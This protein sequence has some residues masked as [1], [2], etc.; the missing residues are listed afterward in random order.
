MRNLYVPWWG[1]T[2]WEKNPDCVTFPLLLIVQWLVLAFSSF[3]NQFTSFLF[4]K[5]EQMSTSSTRYTLNGREWKRT[6][7]LIHKGLK[8]QIPMMSQSITLTLMFCLFHTACNTM[9]TS[10][11]GEVLS[12]CMYIYVC[13]W[14]VCACTNTC[15]SERCVY[16]Q[17]YV[18]PRCVCMY[19]FVCFW[20]GSN[21]NVTFKAD[22]Y[23]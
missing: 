21:G 1:D 2:V 11:M 10:L 12:V 5:R 19:K 15:D 4:S 17:V 20:E 22:Y 3:W 9:Q 23:R 6:F 14:E 16:V 8:Y 13:F 7:H 18:I